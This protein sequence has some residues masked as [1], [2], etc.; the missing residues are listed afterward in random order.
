[1]KMEMRTQVTRDTEAV[2]LDEDVVPRVELAA[3]GRDLGF[4]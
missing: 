1:M 4:Q 3:D 2:G